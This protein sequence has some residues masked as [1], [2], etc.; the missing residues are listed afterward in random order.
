MENHNNW[1]EIANDI[2]KVA[3]NIKNKIDQEDLVDDLK[4]M[5]KSTIENSSNIIKSLMKS[6]ETTIKDDEIKNEAKS[7]LESINEELV[8]VLKISKI[9][10]N[11]VISEEE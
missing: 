4:D 5:F 11:D 6:V 1:S 7:I 3:K 2:N 10:P 9:K 8:N